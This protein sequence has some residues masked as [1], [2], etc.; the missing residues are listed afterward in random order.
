MSISFMRCDDRIIHGQVVTRWAQE[1]KCDGIIAVNDAAAGN[2]LLR[3][4]LKASA[5]IKTFVWSEEQFL[6]KMKEAEESKKNYFII[7]KE[8][9][10]MASLLV[11]HGMQPDTKVLNVGPQ[12]AKE[13]TIAVNKNCDITKEEIKAYEKIHQAGYEIEYQIIPDSTKVTYANVREKLLKEM[14]G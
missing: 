4:A 13:E 5:G 8:P 2:P 6:I 3:R 11:E 7:T 9:L 12:S 10:T 14:E 1:R